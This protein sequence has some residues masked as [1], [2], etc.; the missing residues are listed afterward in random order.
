MKLLND[1]SGK[2]I[3]SGLAELSSSFKSRYNSV[4]FNI[5]KGSRFGTQLG[6]NHLM[7][8]SELVSEIKVL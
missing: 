3:N 5:L 7:E 1:S 4:S 2:R 8:L 6:Q